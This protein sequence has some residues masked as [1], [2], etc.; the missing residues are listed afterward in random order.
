MPSL[1]S[2]NDSPDHEDSLSQDGF[3]KDIAEV[4]KNCTPPKGIGINGYWGTGKTSA[5]IQLHKELTGLTPFDNEK[6]P[7]ASEVI[8]VWFEAWRYQHE[9]LPIVALLN[10]IRAG[11]GLWTKVVEEA[12]K[13][14]GVTLLGV[15]G[16]FDETIKAASGG[17]I[18]PKLGEISKIGQQWES[19]RYK[20]QLPSQNISLLLESAIGEVVGSKKKLVIFI[21]DLDRCT[22]STALKLLEGIKVYLNLKNCVVVFGMDQRQIERALIKALDLESENGEH[23]A[24]EYLE[25]ICQDIY[26][27]PLP[28]QQIKWEYLESL[29]NKLDLGEGSYCHHL[30]SVLTEYDCLPANPRKIKALANRFAVILRRNIMTSDETKIVNTTIRRQYALLV[31]MTIIYTFHRQL[32]EQL[33]KNPD[34]INTVIMY[35]QNSEGVDGALLEPMSGIK[36]SHNGD[37][38]LPTNPSDSNVFRLHQLFNGLDTITTDEI[39]VFLGK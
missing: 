10:E 22:P 33:E 23:Q 20:T 14:G 21:D 3:I 38:L 36:P 6:I 4:I 29:L 24:R 37:K 30:K 15:L 1:L 13:L 27:L 11:F 32:N 35:A 31:A 26:H 25:K 5:L 2:H 18:T 7:E 8:P 12:G 16:A 19:E 39:K 9:P 17:V 28:S 34:Y